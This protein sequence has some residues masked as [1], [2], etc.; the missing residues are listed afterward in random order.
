M[1]VT[2]ELPTLTSQHRRRS[3]V[4]TAWPI[5]L[6][7]HRILLKKW[8]AT[9][10]LGAFLLCG[11]CVSNSPFPACV[12]SGYWSENSAPA[13][14]P[15]SLCNTGSG[16]VSDS[17]HFF[18]YLFSSSV[19]HFIRNSVTRYLLYLLTFFLQ[20]AR[21]FA[22]WHQFVDYC[23]L[24][25]FSLLSIVRSICLCFCSAYLSSNWHFLQ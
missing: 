3:A 13:H 9:H 24:V 20:F 25:C 22:R 10:Q 8:V 16:K 6:T 18:F 12:P 17:K 14:A 2:Y 11:A 1:Q 21:L 5:Y 15:A 19:F 4:L 7:K 23:T